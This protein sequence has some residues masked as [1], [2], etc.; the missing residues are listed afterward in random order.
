VTL[1]EVAHRDLIEHVFLWRLPRSHAQHD[2]VAV[3]SAP[4]DNER[5]D[6]RRGD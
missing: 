4:S 1:L 2:G 3:R 6:E 5:A